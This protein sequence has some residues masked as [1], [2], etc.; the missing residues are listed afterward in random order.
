M[1]AVL[2]RIRFKNY[3]GKLGKWSGRNRR[4]LNTEKWKVVHLSNNMNSQ[5]TEEGVMG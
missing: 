3:V 5:S 4:Q 2:G 1:H